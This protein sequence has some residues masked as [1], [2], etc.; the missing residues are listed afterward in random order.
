LDE[1]EVRQQEHRLG[2][3]KHRTV[4]PCTSRVSN[5]S[6]SEDGVEDTAK[7]LIVPEKGE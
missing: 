1:N 4:H 2:K 6:D 3:E 5:L 7:K